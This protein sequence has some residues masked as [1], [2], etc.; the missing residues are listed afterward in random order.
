M[1][2]KIFFLLL[3]I[4]YFIL[5]GRLNLCSPDEYRYGQIP[6]EMIKSHRYFTPTLNYLNYFEKPVLYYWTIILSYKIF[7]VSPFSLRLVS[8]LSAILIIILGYY[9]VKK[10]FNNYIATL[11]TIFL[12]ASLLFFSLSQIAII[13]MYLTLYL[14]ISFYSFYLFFTEQKKVY[15][16][17]FNLA[18][19]AGFLTKGLISII[20]P[21]IT[22]LLFLFIYDRKRIVPSILNIINLIFIGA[23]ILYLIIME[24]INPG[25]FDFFIINQHFY[26]FLKTSEHNE[27]YFYYIE[28]LG[29]GLF[30]FWFLFIKLSKIK[31]Y[32]SNKFFVYSIIWI[33]FIFFFFTISKSK[34]LPYILPVL[35]QI[36]IILAFIFSELKGKEKKIFNY[37]FLLCN[38]ILS[39]GLVIFSLIKDIFQLKFIIFE[40]I[41]FSVI[42]F[43]FIKTKTNIKKLMASSII[44]ILTFGILTPKINN[45]LES[46]K[47]Q[48]KLNKVLLKKNLNNSDIFCYH[49]YL[50]SLNYYQQKQIKLVAYKGELEYGIKTNRTNNKIYYT[51]EEFGNYIKSLSMPI[52]I[53]VRNGNDR[54][55]LF[56]I[57]NNKKYKIIFDEKDFAVVEVDL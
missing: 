4:L 43:I 27:N 50:Q 47:S 14:T 19:T 41:L 49:S 10:Y 33:F 1:L 2:R 48:D 29:A 46:D 56:R 30:P 45:I 52:L 32:F 37:L 34:L 36:S 25:H 6:L 31:K 54:K 16:L 42:I 55:A 57:L 39:F 5:I 53:V 21:I 17:I 40:I 8:S 24:K 7:G 35:P 15:L 28:I 38:I 18:I 13:D 3:V 51:D 20:F 44:V 26:R 22:G 11:S 12:S 9:F 23:T